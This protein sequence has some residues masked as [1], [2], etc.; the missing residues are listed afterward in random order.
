MERSQGALALSI[1]CNALR[2][3]AGIPAKF[4][5]F[6]AIGILSSGQMLVHK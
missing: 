6:P 5:A 2:S 1:F 4:C 3:K